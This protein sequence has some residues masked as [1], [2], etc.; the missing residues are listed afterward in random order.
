M[1]LALGVY[2]AQLKVI[3]SRNNSTCIIMRYKVVLEVSAD[4]SSKK[5]AE[6]A[7]SSTSADGKLIVAYQVRMSSI[8]QTAVGRKLTSIFPVTQ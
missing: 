1:C 3:N 5:K 2:T 6:R 8:L 7:T 4:Q